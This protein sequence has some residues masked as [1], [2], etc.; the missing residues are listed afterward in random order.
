VL[1]DRVEGEPGQGPDHRVEGND[2]EG[3]GMNEGKHKKPIG[4][5]P[6]MV[7]QAQIKKKPL[8]GGYGEN[9]ALRLRNP[10]HQ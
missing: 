10:K 5:R 8:R 9:L 6:V 7:K 3:V 2:R 4:K 1:K